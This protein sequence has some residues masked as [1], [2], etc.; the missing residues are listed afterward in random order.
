MTPAGSEEIRFSQRGPLGVITL[1]RP[2]ALNALTLAM[3]RL[4]HPALQAW[5]GDTS[6]RAVV[7]EGEGERAFCAGGDVRAVWEAGK[8]GHRPGE[9]GQMTADFFREEYRLNHLIHHYSKPY[10]ALIDGIRRFFA[11][12]FKRP[13]PGPIDATRILPVT[14]VVTVLLGAMTLLLVY[15]DIVKPITLQ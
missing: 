5:A 9:P 1:T 12:I 6:V 7:I 10:I 15:A 2:K 13:E 4:I 8:A 11:R 14:L 3:I